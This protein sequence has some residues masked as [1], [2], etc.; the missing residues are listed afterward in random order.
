MLKANLLHSASY[1]VMIEFCICFLCLCLRVR[2]TDC[3]SFMSV[4][5]STKSALV[6]VI[7]LDQDVLKPWAVAEGIRVILLL[8]CYCKQK[9]GDLHMLVS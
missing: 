1:T 2:D 6:A 7:S 9:L 8:F 4:G 5:D 3:P